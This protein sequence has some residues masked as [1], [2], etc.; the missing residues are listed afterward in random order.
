[1]QNSSSTDYFDTGSNFQDIFEKCKACRSELYNAT[2]QLENIERLSGQLTQ[3]IRAFNASIQTYSLYENDN[4]SAV[5]KFRDS[6]A[7][8]NE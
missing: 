7:S 5:F 8:M 1:M 3:A 2:A 4:E 6:F